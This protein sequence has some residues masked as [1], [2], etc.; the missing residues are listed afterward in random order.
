MYSLLTNR[1]C[2]RSLHENRTA[3]VSHKVNYLNYMG[4]SGL[5]TFCNKNIISRKTIVLKDCGFDIHNWRLENLTTFAK[6]KHHYVPAT[7]ETQ[8]LANAKKTCNAYFDTCVE[9]KNALHI[10]WCMCQENFCTHSKPKIHRS[11]HVS[12]AAFVHF[13]FMAAQLSVI[14]LKLICTPKLMGKPC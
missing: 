3:T 9:R 10:I 11:E 1:V 14:K 13:L 5:I 12:H 8:P 6:I 4:A 2:A 7:K